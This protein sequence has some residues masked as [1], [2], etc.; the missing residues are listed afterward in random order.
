MNNKQCI[1]I[2]SFA[3]HWGEGVSQIRAIH[4][5]DH[6]SLH[7]RKFT[8]EGKSAQLGLFLAFHAIAT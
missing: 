5:I 3:Q 1:E 8:K 2:E 7:V 4:A 6:F